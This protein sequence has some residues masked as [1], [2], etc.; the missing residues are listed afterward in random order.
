MS[1]QREHWEEIW[2]DLESQLEPPIIGFGREY[3]NVKGVLNQWKSEERLFSK[4]NN[5]IILYLYMMSCNGKIPVLPEWFKLQYS[6]H[7]I[8]NTVDKEKLK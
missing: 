5:V 3:S 6:N 4:V 2:R 1:V 7:L 8:N